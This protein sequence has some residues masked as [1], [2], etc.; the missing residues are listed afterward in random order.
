MIII[1]RQVEILA[2][3]LVKKNCKLVTAESCTG[4]GLAE[5]LTR[6]SGSSA[7]FDRGYVVYSNDSKIDLLSVS[8][9]TLETF[10]AVSEETAIA[11]AK[12]A[13]QH[14]NADY[15]VSI[16]GIAGPNGGS[17]EKPVGMVCFALCDRQ[18]NNNII[19]RCINLDG[20]RL[21]IREQSCILV[22]QEL[23]NLLE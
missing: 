1:S 13:L 6:F 17:E 18:E 7:W 3:F 16:T 19:S 22:I 8:L 20:D 23:I 4:G 9:E 14:S 11:M 15:S 2:N 5:I 21:K 12:G 10:G